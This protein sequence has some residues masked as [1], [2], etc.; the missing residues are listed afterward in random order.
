MQIQEV[1]LDDENESLIE[2]NVEFVYLM[3]PSEWTCLYHR[4]LVYLADLGIDIVKD[5]SASCNNKNQNIIF[6]WN[7]F[8]SAVAARQLG[9]NQQADFFIKYITEQLNLTYKHMGT[10]IYNGTNIYP[11]SEDGRL[12]A[13]CSCSENKA[14]FKVDIETGRLYQEYLDGKDYYIEE[15]NLMVEDENKI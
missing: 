11:I 14:T 4:L 13:L 2:T 5:C 6:C 15:E 7:L 9:N 10:D 8:Q 12:R 1:Y 3:I